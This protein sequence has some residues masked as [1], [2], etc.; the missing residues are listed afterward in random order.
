MKTPL[1]SLRSQTE[2]LMKDKISDSHGLMA[3]LYE[4]G[5]LKQEV[6]GYLGAIVLSHSNQVELFVSEIPPI[7][8][9]Y[10]S[11]HYPMVD[12]IPKIPNVQEDYQ[13]GF[14]IVIKGI[15]FYLNREK[16]FT[17]L[18]QHFEGL[19]PTDNEGLK[20]SFLTDAGVDRQMDPQELSPKSNDTR[21]LYNLG[22]LVNFAAQWMKK[23]GQPFIAEGAS[24]EISRSHAIE[25]LRRYVACLSEGNPKYDDVIIQEVLAD[26][27]LEK[28]I[29]VFMTRLD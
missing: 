14:V 24:Y 22:I 11:S 6:E 10:F 15:R 26:E 23:V 8:V 21:G 3:F 28:Q 7:K 5:L 16:S 18:S 19:V 17:P 1:E 25:G 20:Y 9:D 2:D 13:S 4:A 12:L 27:E 29:E